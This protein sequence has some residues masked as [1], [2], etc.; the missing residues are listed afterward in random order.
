MQL[1]LQIYSYKDSINSFII[2]VMW[3][4]RELFTCL[5]YIF[6][7]ISSAYSFFIHF[8]KVLFSLGLVQALVFVWHL[9]LKS[10]YKYFDY[11]L[12]GLPFIFQMNFNWRYLININEINLDSIVPILHLH[13]SLAPSFFQGPYAF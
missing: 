5:L 10:I 7:R 12:L 11:H 2:E 6:F 13:L 4:L 3:F 9:A 1:V 8:I